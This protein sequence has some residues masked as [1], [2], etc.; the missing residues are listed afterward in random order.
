MAEPA[1]KTKYGPYYESALW[2]QLPQR[3]AVGKPAITSAQLAGATYGELEARYETQFQR[4]QAAAARAEATQQREAIEKATKSQATGETIKGAGALLSGG[5]QAYRFLKGKP[6]TPGTVPSVAPQTTPFE[7]A[8][9]PETT[10]YGLDWATSP[11]EWAEAPSMG[12]DLSYVGEYP[13]EA[14]TSIIGDTAAT[15]GEA[16][17]DVAPTVVEAGTELATQ[18]VPVVGPILS[19]AK[20]VFDI[21]SGK[22]VEGGIGLILGNV[23]K[24]P[25]EF[26]I[27]GK[28]EED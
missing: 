4:Q 12:T 8:V 11:T 15:A 17:L 23:F 21:A 20:N 6:G 7:Q 22:P 16:A 18:Q 24:V 5:A 10:Q 3:E 13:I 19:T 1:I 27:G 14:A 2:R 26:A 9:S 25:A 28:G